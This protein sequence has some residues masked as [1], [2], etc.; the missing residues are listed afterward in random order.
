MDLS[1]RRWVWSLFGNDDCFVSTGGSKEKQVVT[2]TGT[3]E[4]GMGEMGEVLRR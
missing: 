3:G 1:V 2:V 4:I